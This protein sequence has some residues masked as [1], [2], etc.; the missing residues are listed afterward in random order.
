MS[1]E[2]VIKCARCNR[3]MVVAP[4]LLF[5]H[6][7]LEI[8]VMR[9]DCKDVKQASAADDSGEGVMELSL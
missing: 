2:I 7:T 1:M 9:C 4:P 3:E 8:T 6:P 5:K